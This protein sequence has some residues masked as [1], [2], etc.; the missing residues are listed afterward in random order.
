MEAPCLSRDEPLALPQATTT[1]AKERDDNTSM[2]GPAPDLSDA[3]FALPAI[4]RRSLSDVPSMPPRTADRSLPMR[5]VEPCKSRR[6][7]HERVALERVERS[8]D[9]VLRVVQ[10]G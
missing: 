9:R 10:V 6:A 3:A 1:T 4:L 5:R 8:F 7:R 2:N